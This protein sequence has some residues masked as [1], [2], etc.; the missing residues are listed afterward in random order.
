MLHSEFAIWV[1]MIS[2]TAQVL[3][4][5]SQFGNQKG[6]L[7]TENPTMVDGAGTAKHQSRFYSIAAAAELFGMSVATL[8]RAIRSGEF[9]AIKIRGRYV[10]PAQAI[11]AM[12]QEA[13]VSGC[14][15][16]TSAFALVKK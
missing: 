14:L 3:Y 13:L 1:R 6:S 9:P 8:Y 12:E 2:N 4:S 16:D 11:D 15:V 5:G 7:M 10:I